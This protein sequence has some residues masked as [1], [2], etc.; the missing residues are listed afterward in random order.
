MMNHGTQLD[1]RHAADRIIARL[2]ETDHI[3]A[4]I[5]ERVNTVLDAYTQEQDNVIPLQT[6]REI[7]RHVLSRLG[8]CGD[9]GPQRSSHLKP[10]SD[11][12]EDRH[13]VVSERTSTLAKQISDELQERIDFSLLG[14]KPPATQRSEIR[15]LIAE[16]CSEQ[17]LEINR[18]EREAIAQMILDDMLGL[19]PLEALLADESITDIMINGCDHVYIERHGALERTSVKFR[20]NSQI[21]NVVNRIVAEVGRRIDESSP[22]VDARLKDGSRVHVVIPPL[23]IDGPT[24][25]IRRFPQQQITLSDLV[26]FGSM[27]NQMADFLNLA[28]RMRLNILISGGTGSGKTTLLNAMSQKIPPTERLV[29]IEDAAELRLQ[30]PHVVRLET[31]P[32]SMEGRGEVTMRSLVR[33]ALRMR[34]DRIIL[35]EVRG[36]EVIDLLQAM[37]TG[38]EGS[39]CTLH[40]NSPRDALTRVENMVAMTGLKMPTDLIRSQLRDAVNLIIQ[41]S[42][43]RDGRRRVTSISEL[44]GL[45]GGVVTMQDLFS[46]EFDRKTTQARI[47]GQYTYS[48]FRPLF[49]D[50]AAEFGLDAELTQ[51]LRR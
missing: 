10:V 5:I 23:A 50:R 24:V 20:D 31:R 43:M 9:P 4:P 21:M 19:G 38:H 33:N 8:T 46:F 16:I 28:A 13:K 39:M 25:T 51:I 27:S 45:S 36:D 1:P 49:A 42:R 48:G 37:N 2:A 15:D 12:N 41:I 35:G 6:Q 18:S 40:A 32:E 29:T 30:I 3:E 47:S 14:A 44:V 7:M 17:R 34:P 11:N 22:M 26:S